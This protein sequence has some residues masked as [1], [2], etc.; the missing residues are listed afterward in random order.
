MPDGDP[1]KI[2][3]LGGGF[4]GRG[5]AQE[6]AKLLPRPEDG[7]ITLVDE[8]NFL[9]FTPMLTEVAGGEL[10]ADHI[11]SSPHHLSRRVGFVQGRIEQIDLNQKH[12]KLTQEAEGS[13]TSPQSQIGQADHLVIAL[14]SV[15]NF[16]GIP[17]LRE[18]SLQ[19]KRLRDA[20]AVR[21]RVLA[22]LERA[23]AERDPAVRRRL[24]TFVVGG[25]GFT[26]V[27]TM[28]AMNDLVR[29]SVRFFPH[30]PLGEIQTLLIHPGDRLLPELSPS[31]AAYAQKKLERRGV[32]VRLKTT[33]SGAGDGFVEIAGGTR[34]HTQ[35]LVWAAGVTP[36]PVIATLDC[37]RGKHGGLTVDSS[38][39]VPEHPGVWALGD[40]AEVPQPGS[41]HS[42]APTAQ[43][44]TREG[45]LVAQNIVAA[46]Q[47]GQTRQFT[48]QPIG[49]L[50]LVGR[51]SGVARVYGLNF[52]GVLAWAM[53]RLIY[54]VKM[55]DGRQ[56]VRIL[57]DWLL[58][59][60][61]GRPIVELPLAAQHYR[62]LK[63]DG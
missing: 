45:R 62:H 34:I 38:C 47:G 39:R 51:H 32:E 60:I 12:V 2:V 57:L 48:F 17:G 42:Y 35:T 10:D 33:I 21:N 22:L 6:L 16:H 14:G 4:A 30:I 53:W 44:A 37:Q 52:S 11:T 36:S 50:A 56:R 26:G 41:H 31:L 20:D 63:Q 18:H 43:N 61:L 5:V 46:L 49:E 27:E 24:L 55:P 8:H 3:I 13:G 28:A 15:P 54:L 25:G 23:N 29:A 58:D 40:C 19:M 59:V 9:L 7:D 1:P